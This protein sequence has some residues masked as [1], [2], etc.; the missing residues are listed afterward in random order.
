MARWGERTKPF[1]DILHSWLLDTPWQP[2]HGGA[3]GG[4]GGG[5]V[6]AGASGAG[7]STTAL[8][9]V[10]AGWHYA[11]DD[12]VVI[13]GDREPR[14][15]NLYASARLRRDMA[16]R[17][18]EFRPAQIGTIT[19]FGDER[20]DLLLSR[21]VPTA[22]IDGFPV[23]AILLPSV[24]SGSR[25]GLRPATATQAMIALS[26]VTLHFLRTG[27]ARTFE[28]IGRFVESLPVYWLDLGRDLDALPSLIATETGSGP[29]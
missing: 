2:V 10:R 11:G 17:L 23:R 6:L 8:A 1:L 5:I 18:A 26:S 12:Y 28:K 22:R 19:T 15:E 20:C 21:M 24:A 29:R 14:V 13:G 16:E 27:A 9:C 25:S 3:I 4:P 7:K